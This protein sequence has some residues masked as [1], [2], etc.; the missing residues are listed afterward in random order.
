MAKIITVGNQKGGVGKTTTTLTLGAGLKKKGYSVLFIDLDSQKN[1]SN[2]LRAQLD[3]VPNILDLLLNQATINQAG[4]EKNSI[5]IK[6][7]IQSTPTGDII[8]STSLLSTADMKFVDVMGR[9]QL[10]KDALNT[11]KNEYDYIL[12]DTPPALSI[13]TVNAFSTSDSIII[14]MKADKYSLDGLGQL[15]NT[16]N[17]IQKKINPALTI[18]GILFIEYNPRTALTK[19]LT[20]ETKQI[21]EKIGIKVFNSYIRKSVSVPESQLKKTNLLDYPWS[22]AQLDYKSFIDEFLSNRGE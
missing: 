5:N 2:S 16:I 15:Y 11:I 14:P 7:Y 8:P 22:T 6:N 20:K 17:I 10:L 3:N 21:A 18:D 13:L 12:I 4:T 19:A 1:L 9:E